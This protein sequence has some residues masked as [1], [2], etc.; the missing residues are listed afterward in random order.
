MAA[1][2]FFEALASGRE[3]EHDDPDPVEFAR[4]NGLMVLFNEGVRVVFETHLERM[5]HDLEARWRELIAG[6]ARSEAIGHH[7]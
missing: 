5:P 4:V 3:L 1:R 7:T 2:Q 6:G